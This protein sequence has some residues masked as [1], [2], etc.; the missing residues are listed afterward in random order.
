MPEWR[1][2]IE[3]LPLPSSGRLQDRQATTDLAGWLRLNHASLLVVQ[4]QPVDDVRQFQRA[5]R[6]IWPTKR[7]TSALAFSSKRGGA[8]QHLVG[9]SALPAAS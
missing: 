1:Q 6:A 3:T 5:Q 7:E 8:R 9:I 2:V 4:I